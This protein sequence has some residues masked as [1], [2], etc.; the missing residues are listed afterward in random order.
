[1]LPFITGSPPHD[2][3]APRGFHGVA[4]GWGSSTLRARRTKA[5]IKCQHRKPA[6]N[7]S[8]LNLFLAIRVRNKVGPDSG[9]PSPPPSMSKQECSPDGEKTLGA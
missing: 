5:R 9:M 1:M 8:S 2:T 3:G 7:G 6:Y 4:S